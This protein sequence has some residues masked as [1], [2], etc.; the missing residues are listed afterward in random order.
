MNKVRVSPFGV[1]VDKTG[2]VVEHFSVDS[3]IDD[4]FAGTERLDRKFPGDAPHSP[5]VWSEGGWTSL[6]EIVRE[7]Q[8]G[9]P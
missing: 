7:S 9:S 1:I 5:A 2:S 8:G 4:V 6:R 3:V